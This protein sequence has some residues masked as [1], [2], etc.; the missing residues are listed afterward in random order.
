MTVSSFDDVPSFPPGTLRWELTVEYVLWEG[1][2]RSRICLPSIWRDATSCKCHVA[3][4][5][6]LPA[7]G[8]AL[9]APAFFFFNFC[10]F[11]SNISLL[12]LISSNIHIAF[13]STFLW[14]CQGSTS[15]LIWLLCFSSCSDGKESACNADWPGFHPWVR[16]IPWRR[17]WH[18][19]QYSCLENSMDR[20]AWLTT[21][22][23]VTKS[24]TQLND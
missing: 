16:K 6:L 20:G 18:P 13:K 9:V 10:Q 2:S 5:V 3:L 24:Q 7:M 15:F 1:T 19:L 17:K 14:Y 12:Y 11:E 22:C 23:G 8:S 21:V 4:S